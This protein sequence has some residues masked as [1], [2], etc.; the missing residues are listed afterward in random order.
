M[1]EIKF[2][3][4]DKQEN[5]IIFKGFHV[6]GEV[7]TFGAIESYCHETAG[8]KHPWDRYHDLILMQCTELLTNSGDYIWEGDILKFVIDGESELGVVRFSK[9]GYW[10]S[11]FEGQSEEL[12]C[13]EIQSLQFEIIGNIYE[14]PELLNN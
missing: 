11:Q 8:S 13:E 1:R 7:T 5:K 10:T 14:N 9:D 4:Y 3:L 12:L 2:R 6:F